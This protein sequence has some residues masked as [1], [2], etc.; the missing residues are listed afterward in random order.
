[1]ND[2]ESFLALSLHGLV[3]KYRDFT[4]GPIDF[5][6]EPGKVVGLVGPN[7][8]GKTTTLNLC[9]GMLRQNQ[10]SIKIFGTENNPNDA[11]WKFNIGFVADEHVFYEYWSVERNLKYISE[12]Y[13]KWS[14]DRAYELA[15]RF[16]LD[17]K[18][19]VNRLSKGNRAKLA[20][21]Q[22]LSYSPKLLLLDEPSSGLDPIVR[23]EF[24]DVLW[25]ENEKG[26]TAILYSTHILSDIGRIAD[27]L[28]FLSNGKL[29]KR[30]PKDELL[31]KWRYISFMCETEISQIA[32]VVEIKHSGNSYMVTSSNHE[33]T[34]KFL[35]EKGIQITQSTPLSIDEIAV[36]IMKNE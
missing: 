13:P 28:A 15:T 6:L 27:E 35:G 19:R 21:I 16:K 12:F 14:W 24:L 22:V 32:D 7:G 25:E 10:G 34:V 23:S 17:L 30:V 26:K 36:Q 5:D 2:N 1:M 18:K 33:S 11:S 3:K 4:L 9:S 31:D 20:L 29:I 8:A